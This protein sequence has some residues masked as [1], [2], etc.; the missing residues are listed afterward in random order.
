MDFFSAAGAS[1][2]FPADSGLS[3]KAAAALPAPTVRVAIVID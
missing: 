1:I 3:D 2:V